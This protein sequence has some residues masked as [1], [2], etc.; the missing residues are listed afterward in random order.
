M[1]EEEREEELHRQIREWLK[2]MTVQQLIEM[3][4]EAPHLIRRFRFEVIQGG[5]QGPK[6]KLK[7]KFTL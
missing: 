4:R 7:S 1:T 2:E 5:R 6:P 3:R